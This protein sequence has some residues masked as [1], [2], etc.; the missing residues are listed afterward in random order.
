M[1]AGELSHIE[2]LAHVYVLR[3][4]NEKRYS[5]ANCVSNNYILH[6]FYVVSNGAL[7]IR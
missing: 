2:S 4:T 5:R 1:P 6:I 3:K 7:M